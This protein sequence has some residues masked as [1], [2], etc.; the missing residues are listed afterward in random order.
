[1]DGS[2][3]SST[4]RLRVRA[5]VDATELRLRRCSRGS[6]FDREFQ[7]GIHLQP[8]LC[9][10]GSRRGQIDLMSGFILDSAATMQHAPVLESLC[11]F[12]GDD[13]SDAPRATRTMQSCRTTSPTPPRAQ[14][15]VRPSPRVT[16]IHRWLLLAHQQSPHQHPKFQL[17]S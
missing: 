13:V 14:A 8:S 10:H 7:P 1:M 6:A 11:A 16:A 3:H 17:P 2:C 15:T 12:R 4:H 9:P 5:G